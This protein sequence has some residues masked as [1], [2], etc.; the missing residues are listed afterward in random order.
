[1][2]RWIPLLISMT[3]AGL[4]AAA[5]LIIEMSLIEEGALSPSGILRRLDREA[6]DFKFRS[7]SDDKLPE[8]QVIIAGIDEK[9]IQRFGLWPWNRSVIADFVDSVTTRGPGG[10]PGEGARVVVFDAVFSD[11]A[12]PRTGPGGLNPI[13]ESFQNRVE[14]DTQLQRIQQQHD[15]AE[16]AVQTLARRLKSQPSEAILEALTGAQKAH[17]AAREILEKA[18]QTLNKST[19][20]QPAPSPEALLAAAIT[21]NS[22]TVLGYFCFFRERDLLGVSPEKHGEGLATLQRSAL[23]QLFSREEQSLE[24]T[25]LSLIKPLPDKHIRDLQ[26]NHEDLIA[27]RAPLPILSEGAAAFGHFNAAPDQD[28]PIRRLGLLYRYGDQ[29]YPALSLVAAAQ[30]FDSKIRPLD[31][32]ILPHT[33]SGVEF[34]G[35]R[36]A[37][38]TPD[39]ELLLNYYQAPERYFPTYSVADFIDGTVSPE[40][41]RAKIVR[42]GMTA[43]GL[44]DLRPN[45]FSP[46]TPGGYIHAMAIQNMLDGRFMQRFYGMALLEAILYL[47]VGLLLGL[48]LPRMPPWSGVLVTLG[49]GGGLY[50]YDSLVLFPSGNWFLAVYPLLEVVCIFIGINVYGYLTEGREKRKIRSAF[51]FY[52]TKSV[53]DEVLEE[54]RKL[55]LGGEKRICTV[56]FSDIRG[57][58][59]ISETL[60]AEKL[61]ALLNEYLTPMTN[62]VFK[63]DGTLDKYMGD[64]IMAIFGAPIAHPD[65]AARA[66]ET[67][68]DMMVSL[69]ALQVDWAQRGLP[70]LDIGIGVNTGPMSVGNMGSEV[71]FDYTVM[72][73]NV[74]LGSRLEGLNKQ[75]G[76]NIII[77]ESTYEKAGGGVFARELDSVRVKGKLEPV[78]IYELLGV[79][80]PSAQQRA[81]IDGFDEGLQHYKAQRWAAATACFSR[82]LEEI[83]P[84]DKVCTLYIERCEAMKEQP[85]KPEWDGVFTITT[86]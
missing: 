1:M 65:H 58:T 30:Y 25:P 26:L 61:V 56:L 55:K 31:G 53:V 59:S 67:A 40:V 71:R 2:K 24:D 15:S 64:A 48:L 72:G 46:T 49:V 84:G 39:G 62:M 50:L 23:S 28:G 42:F 63:H 4:F 85:P 77:S 20:T 78:R 41:Y 80:E 35:P 12:Q 34:G 73:D 76:T 10:E 54:P 11:T 51:Q 43:Q 9:S 36:A 79:G 29:L 22:R 68:L 74:N 69:K 83:A 5:H 8:A 18:R 38:T 16:R 13:Q 7:R 3:I 27:V 37:P 86:K 75:Y 81:R 70:H 44:Y 32:E 52:L 82:V 45:P 33:L 57:F 47:L 19:T 66:C 14:W 21:R 60:E 6:L 17:A